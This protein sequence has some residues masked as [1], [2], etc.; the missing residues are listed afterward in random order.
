EQA[1][2]LNRHQV[3]ARIG[4]WRVVETICQCDSVLGIGAEGRLG[5]RLGSCQL[6]SATFRNR[7]H[8]ACTQDAPE[9]AAG[10]W[11]GIPDD[12]ACTVSWIHHQHGARRNG[13]PCQYRAEIQTGGIGFPPSPPR[14]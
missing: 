8:L 7:A 5:N 4:A 14:W 9:I 2:K 6:V 3:P 11:A 1:T 10:I 12:R 13:P